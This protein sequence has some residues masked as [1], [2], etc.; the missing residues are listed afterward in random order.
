MH[1]RLIKFVLVGFLWVMSFS[2]SADLMNPRVVPE[3]PRVGDEVIFFVDAPYPD[4][5]GG[6]SVTQ[7]GNDFTLFLNAGIRIGGPMDTLV[8]SYA[9]GTIT[10][11]GTYTVTVNSNGLGLPPPISFVVSPARVET[12]PALAPAFLVVLAILFGVVGM[13]FLRG[14]GRSSVL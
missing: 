13:L 12:V 9:L 14:R 1:T 2:V 4:T 11:P 7:S 3:N 6:Y 5:A 10:A 8:L